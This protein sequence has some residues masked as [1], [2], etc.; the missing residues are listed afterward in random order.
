MTVAEIS[1]KLT[2][3]RRQKRQ[4]TTGE[5]AAA[6]DAERNVLN[7]ELEK[8]RKAEQDAAEQAERLSRKRA[9]IEYGIKRRETEVRHIETVEIIKLEREVAAQRSR[10]G[11]I[12]GQ[13]VEQR[14]KLEKLSNEN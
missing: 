14:A 2:E 10:A 7:F 12:R 1:S 4:A 3:L 11:M 8:A 5:E 13:I 6:I 9:E